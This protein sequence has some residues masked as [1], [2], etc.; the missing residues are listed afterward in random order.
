MWD[1]FKHTNICVVGIREGEN[2]A[3][4]ILEIILKKQWLEI[5]QIY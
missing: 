5:S 3:E 1:M 2:G 4:K